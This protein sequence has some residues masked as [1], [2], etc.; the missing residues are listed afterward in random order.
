MTLAFSVQNCSTFTA[1]TNKY[2]NKNRLSV[3]GVGLATGYKLKCPSSIPGRVRF[4]SPSQQP[5][6][7]VTGDSFTG[8]KVAGV[9]SWPLLLPRS[10][11]VELYLYS[12]ICICG[13]VPNYLSTGTTLPLTFI[14]HYN[15][16]QWLENYS[17]AN[18]RSVMNIKYKSGAKVTLCYKSDSELVWRLVLCRFARDTNGVYSKMVA[19]WNV[20]K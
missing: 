9:W 20:F 12:P 5:A 6:P 10:R 4:F 13:I 3:T 11:M 17:I 8:G 14:S 16:G 18:P 7:M 19:R 2:N 15:D 1:A